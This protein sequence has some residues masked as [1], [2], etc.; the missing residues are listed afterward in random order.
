M[1]RYLILIFLSLLIFSLEVYPQTPNPPAVIYFYDDAGNRI[2]RRVINVGERTLDNSLNGGEDGLSNSDTKTPPEEE[3]IDNEDGVI[4]AYPNPTNGAVNIGISP[5]L[6]ENTNAE[7]LIVDISGKQISKGKI[8]EP[9]T[10]L[11]LY[12]EAKGVYIL[13]IIIGERREE[14]QLVKN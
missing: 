5:N 1:A 11:D 12:G 6:L 3:L 14:W 7:Y 13:S 8:T 4:V 2:L 10:M 9:R